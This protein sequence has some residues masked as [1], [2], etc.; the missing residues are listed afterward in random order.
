MALVTVCALQIRETGTKI[1][2]TKSLG[3][4]DIAYTYVP[5]VDRYWCFLT[6]LPATIAMIIKIGLKLRIWESDESMNKTWHITLE[7]EEKMYI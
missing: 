4:Q 2:G 6:C 7:V 3:G 5:C 1:Q